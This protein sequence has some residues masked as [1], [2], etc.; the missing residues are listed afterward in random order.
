LHARQHAQSCGGDAERCLAAAAG[1]LD[2]ASSKHRAGSLNL[3]R[4]IA[5]C[6]VNN[7]YID[8][9]LVWFADGQVE[10]L[11]TPDVDSTG[12]RI[13]SITFAP[14]DRV[15]EL[16]VWTDSS[17]ARVQ[18]VA[19]K[20]ASGARLDGGQGRLTSTAQ[21]R[22]DRP[23]DLGSGLLLGLVGALKPGSKVLSAI[24]FSFLRPP[25]SA[26][27]AVLMPAIRIEE[28]RFTPWAQSTY[29]SPSTNA[30]A[31]R[32]ACP[33]L[34]T[35]KVTT[36]AAYSKA[37]DVQRLKGILEGIGRPTD[38]AASFKQAAALVAS[39][40]QTL[41]ATGEVFTNTWS[42]E[43]RAMPFHAQPRPR[44]LRACCSCPPLPPYP[45]DPVRPKYRR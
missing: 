43:V 11:G 12:S 45:A 42:S 8:A 28:L 15:T 44:S 2:A 14:N 26:A 36:T 40:D 5:L 19:M 35:L 4:R 9:V 3:V 29:R 16:Y 7:S 20:L 30:G 18:G 6:T 34:T 23:G 24:G 41:A 33:V 38:T 32:G 10:R 22:L 25:V 37:S 1:H 21:L 31:V 17:A 13:A 27:L 39:K